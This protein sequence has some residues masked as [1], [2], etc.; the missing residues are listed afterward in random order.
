MEVCLTN[1]VNKVLTLI[2]AA[3]FQK[4]AGKGQYE[5]EGELI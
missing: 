1:T 4:V 2:I 3:Y 5:V